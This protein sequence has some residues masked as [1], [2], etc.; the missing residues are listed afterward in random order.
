[1]TTINRT[2]TSLLGAVFAAEYI[3]NIVPA[4]THQWHKFVP[5][6]ELSYL[7]RRHGA[8]VKLATG[9]EFSPFSFQWRNTKC[10]TMNYGIGAIKGH[11]DHNKNTDDSQKR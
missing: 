7:L 1:M 2:L 4:G 11:T 5:P 6:E 3:L 9:F 8:S 10:M